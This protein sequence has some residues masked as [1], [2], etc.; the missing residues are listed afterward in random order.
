MQIK[1]MFK[2]P[3]DRKIQGVI[4]TGQDDDANALQELEEYV[5]TPELEHHF[6]DFFDAYKRSI[7][8]QTSEMGVWISGFFGSGKS[9]F[10]K[11]LSYILTNKRVG[12]RYALD[13]FDD[14]DPMIL[15]DMR[16][17]ANTPTV[18]ILF[19]IDSESESSSKQNKDAIVDVFLKV[20]NE[21]QGFCGSLPYV[22]D[23]EHRLTVEHKLEEFQ[24]AFKE[25]N[26]S[27]W[28]DSRQDFDF[29]QDDVVD[30]LVKINFMSYDAARNWCTKT[31]TPYQISIED[32]AKRVKDYIDK[33]RK[34]PPRRLYGR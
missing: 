6:G 17:A 4:I 34:Q 29:I 21:M 26:G 27:S 7:K 12:D 32:F 28:E 11:I 25:I 10:L 14:I 3:I 2:K 5:I 30:A 23:L 33:K 1:D 19:N 8:G 13:Y 15:A 18:V 24:A 16:L 9:L 31:S 22:A 20:F